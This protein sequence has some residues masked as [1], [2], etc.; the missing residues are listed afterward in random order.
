VRGNIWWPLQPCGDSGSRTV[1]WLSSSQ[2]STVSDKLIGERRLL[3]LYVIVKIYYCTNSWQLPCQHV[4]VLAMERTHQGQHI[5]RQVKESFDK[6]IHVFFRRQ[7]QRFELVVYM[8][9]RILQAL[10]LLVSS[11]F[12]PTPQSLL[13][14][15]S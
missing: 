14:R 15:S 4:C 10:D 8:M 13:V 3:I 12:M 9:P 7:K 2:G 11:L 1:Q 5:C 6:F